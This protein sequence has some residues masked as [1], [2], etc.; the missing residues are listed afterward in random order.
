MSFLPPGAVPTIAKRAPSPG[1]PPAH[2]L[3]GDSEDQL[4]LLIEGVKDYAIFMLDESGRIANWNAGAQ[5]IKGYAAE[6][7]IGQHFS[8]FYPAEA[9]QRRW[10]EHELR[11]ARTSGRFEDEGWRV[12]KDGSMF[13]ANV[14]IT[15]L[16]DQQGRPR[17]F[18][19]VT[20]D[21]T[22]RKQVEELRNTERQM[23]EF[24]AMLA[25]ELRNPLAPIQTALDIMAL[26]P[27]DLSKITWSRDL[28][29]RQVRQLTR[30]V[31]DL[32]DV[33]R[34]TCG[35][36]ELRREAVDLAPLIAATVDTLRPRIAA[37]QHILEV[38]LPTASL[39][40]MVDTVRFTQVIAN[41]VNNAI[42]YTPNGGRIYVRASVE[43]ESAI[44]VVGDNGIGIAQHL[45]TRIFDVFV[46]G[47][48]AL[49]RRE[50]GLGIGLAL[51]KRLVE[52]HNG[53]VSAHSAG[54]GRGSEF[55]L[56]LPLIQAGT[57]KGVDLAP[58]ASAAARKLRILVVDDSDDA[59]STLA[60]LLKTLGHD[61]RV[62]SDGFAALDAAP[63][64]LP[65]VVL[66]DIGLPLMD[67]FKVASR[68][69]Q[70]PSMADTVLVACTGYGHERE[71]TRA[72][73]AGFHHHLVKPIELQQLERIL[74]SVPALPLAG[75]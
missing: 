21:L 4:R 38:S 57:R 49:D 43:D 25:H 1:S 32:L 61:V 42:K 66:L 52:L 47:D 24:L 31:D 68:L 36:I 18:V 13:W 26:R 54:P 41:L 46:Q 15:A 71:R 28:I 19:K 72:V 3:V 56:S 17:G 27:D 59:A 48:R 30:L 33:S 75:D 12:R 2:P 63:E 22:A 53:S 58:A 23:T 37:R 16:Y 74:D 20:R 55:T 62:A 5:H 39:P 50:G 44:V 60:A 40:V 51:V 45:L 10:P 11:V 35:K 70:M 73:E 64:F 7:I 69:A 14:I 34:I 9:K 67:G 65:H 6:E 8:V 29:A